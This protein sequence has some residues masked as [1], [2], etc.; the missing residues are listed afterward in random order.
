[1]PRENTLR[2]YHGMQVWRGDSETENS[3]RFQDRQVDQFVKK[4]SILAND[5]SALPT[6][7]DEITR[8]FVSHEAATLP[9]RFH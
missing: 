6:F 3:I 1:M 9:A 2:F 5:L 7:I 4:E 8:K